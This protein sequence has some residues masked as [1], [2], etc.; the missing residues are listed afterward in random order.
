MN[1]KKQTKI[2]A[3]VIAS[4]LAIG[5]LIPAAMYIFAADEKP[6]RTS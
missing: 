1:K 5:M 4:L 6:Q 3:I 2:I